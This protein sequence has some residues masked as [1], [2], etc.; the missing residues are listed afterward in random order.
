MAS[1]VIVDLPEARKSLI[2]KCRNGGLDRGTGRA[3]D[4]LRHVQGRRP[5]HDHD[6]YQAA[7]K[8]WRQIGKFY[9]DA[10][11]ESRVSLQARQS[12]R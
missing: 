10:L 6:G 12:G 2:Y 3:V 7:G 8:T 1:R 4:D 9:R 5:R 11:A